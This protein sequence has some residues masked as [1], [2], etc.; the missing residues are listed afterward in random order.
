GDSAASSKTFESIKPGAYSV[1]ENPVDPS[2]EF[3]HVTCT[4]SGLSTTWSA[5]GSAL[6]INLGPGGGADCTYYNTRKPTLTGTK[7]PV[8]SGDNGSFALQ[9]DGATKTIGG[10]G[11]TTGVVIVSAGQH[12]VTE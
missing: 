9:V 4:P 1:S 5:N 7:A 10:N 3:D 11:A 6:S 2:W 12:S 8:P